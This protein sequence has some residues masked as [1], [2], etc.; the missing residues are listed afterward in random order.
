MP[1][2]R[3]ASAR[4]PPP[5]PVF[6]GLPGT[7]DPFKG[8]SK[9]CR[10]LQR[11]LLSGDNQ[12][13]KGQCSEKS[14]RLLG[15]ADRAQ[16][17]EGQEGQGADRGIGATWEQASAWQRAGKHGGEAREGQGKIAEFP[18]HLLSLQGE[19]TIDNGLK[20]MKVNTGSALGKEL[21]SPRRTDHT[22][23]DKETHK[24]DLTDTWG[25]ECTAALIGQWRQAN[26]V[27]I[28]KKMVK[29]LPRATDWW[30][31]C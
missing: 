13:N 10:V 25:I 31:R 8:R 4:P 17:D 29:W 28:S 18:F 11:T 14:M 20:D 23:E 9:P 2:Q 15:N 26:T 22:S 3:A 27:L 1:T 6:P 5:P 30:S 7:Q 24:Q 21:K 19:R 16:S 12:R